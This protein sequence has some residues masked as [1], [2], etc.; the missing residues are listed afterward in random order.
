MSS[1][2]LLRPGSRLGVYPQRL[3]TT[4]GRF[5]QFADDWLVR[6]SR[7]ATWRKYRQ[8]SVVG[9]VNR[10]AAGLDELDDNALKLQ[11][12][13]IRY[14]LHRD[15]LHGDLVVTTFALIREYAKRHLQLVHYD[16]Q[17][18]GGW[19]IVHG[20]MAEM[21]TGEGKSFTATLPAATAAL[22]GIPV[23]VITSNEYLA[24]RDAEEMRPLYEAM[25]PWG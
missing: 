16:V 6:L 19:I 1:H 20:N 12:E 23:H 9:R 7:F 13:S 21:A 4:R 3:E 5:E 15:G 2:T 14:K 11:C 22:G 10:A 8:Q 18:Y 17:L 24:A 25:K